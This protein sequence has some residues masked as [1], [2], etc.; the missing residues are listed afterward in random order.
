[1]PRSGG[2]LGSI[3]AV[4]AALVVALLG[5]LSSAP[6]P[7]A[8]AAAARIRIGVYDARALPRHEEAAFPSLLA[9]IAKRA[10]LVAITERADFESDRVEL[11]DV[12]GALAAALRSGG[13]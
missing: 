7:P 11:V 12:T 6:D 13:R 9:A 5:G 8:P 1:M 2:S 3:L 4:G 10:D